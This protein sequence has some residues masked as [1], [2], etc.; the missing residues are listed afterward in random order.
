MNPPNP[1]RAH[2]NRRMI[3]DFLA[4]RRRIGNRVAAGFLLAAVAS[5][6]VLAVAPAAG[7]APS[8]AAG[9]SATLTTAATTPSGLV[10]WS[11]IP[12]TAAAPDTRTTFNYASVAPGTTITD[13]VAV[14]NRSSQSVAFTIDATDA[15]GTTA[16]NTLLLMPSTQ[17]PVDIGSWVSVDGHTG[18]LSVVIGAGKGVIEPF[19]ISVPRNAKPGDHTGAL[20]ASVTF[21]ARA[22]NG[23]LV[24][25]EHRLGV[26]MFLR[27][28][29]PLSAG[30]RVEAVSVGSR[31]TISP[32]GST[33]TNVTYTVHNTG[34]VRLAGSAL[35]SVSGLFGASLS[36]GSKPL[37][38][39]L[40]GDS[41]RITVAPGSLYP[42]GPI[43]AHV[44]VGPAA[45]AGG[46]ALAAPLADVTG[47]ASLF[48]VPW[49]LLVVVILTAG[50]IVGLAQLLR[51]RRRRLGE[52]LAAVAEHARKETENRLLGQS[53]KSSSAGPQGKA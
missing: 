42:F 50:V 53:G 23:A 27:V 32:V 47:S 22:K 15:T 46:I 5:A 49:A 16:S 39:V 41:V 12:A 17:K 33:A 43:T 28:A 52:T 20:F 38:T 24:A 25:E 4:R 3:R 8:S 10:S 37:P 51:W 48:A 35:V 26:P 29:G 45:P 44:R 1:H 36:T 6:A 34:N 7:A 2:A 21:N 30:L 31:G 13:H 11:V 40:P 9:R 19:R 14:L 18:K